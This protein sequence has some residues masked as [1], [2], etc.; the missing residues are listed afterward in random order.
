MDNGK[1]EPSSD[2]ASETKELAANKVESV[3]KYSLV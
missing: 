1:N 2:Y 3:V